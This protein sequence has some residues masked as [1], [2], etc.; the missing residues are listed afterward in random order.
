M[1]VYV[2]VYAPGGRAVCM[3]EGVCLCVYVCV[4]VCA[5]VYVCMCA[6]RVY[7]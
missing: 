5:S 6:C 2:C 3:C 1:C 7:V 4:Y